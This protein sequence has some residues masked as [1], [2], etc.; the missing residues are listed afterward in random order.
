MPLISDF[1]AIDRHPYEESRVAR[2][3]GPLLANDEFG[4]VWVVETA[5]RLLG[6]AVGYV[7]L[8]A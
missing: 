3:L 6:Y 4:Q 2:A 1:Y 5:G 8:L 7:E